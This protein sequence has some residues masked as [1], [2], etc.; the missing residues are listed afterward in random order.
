MPGVDNF[1]YDVH[2]SPVFSESVSRIIFHLIIKVSGADEDIGI[3]FD[4]LKEREEFKH[5]CQDIMLEAVKRAKL[6]DGEIQ[7]DYLAQIAVCKL[8][9]QEIAHQFEELITRLNNQVFEYE[10][11]NDDEMILQTISLKEKIQAI[12]HKRNIIVSNVSRKIFEYL[13]EAQV[14]LKERREANY[15]A[16]SLLKEDI[17]INPLLH[18]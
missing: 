2:L 6:G 9:T 5:L 11:T 15:G 14:P 1:H 12:R 4:W 3:E 13:L 10:S 7:I 17:F 16:Q 8:L 18:A